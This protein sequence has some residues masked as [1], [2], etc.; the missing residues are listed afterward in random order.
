MLLSERDARLGAGAGALNPLPLQ[1][2]RDLAADE[3]AVARVL[4]A[5]VRARDDAGRI[6]KGDALRAPP[7]ARRGA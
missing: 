2:R 4:D 5:D 7:R 3:R 6:E 1:I